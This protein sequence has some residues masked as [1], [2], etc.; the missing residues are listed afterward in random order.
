MVEWQYH[1]LFRQ[2]QQAVKLIGT[3]EKVPTTTLQLTVRY[4]LLTTIRKIAEDENSTVINEIFQELIELTI[5]VPSQKI[6]CR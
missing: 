4:R 3:R 2:L 5:S 6:A 1:I